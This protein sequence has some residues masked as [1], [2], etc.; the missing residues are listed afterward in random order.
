MIT[1]IISNTAKKKNLTLPSYITFQ[2]RRRAKTK[3][4]YFFLFSQQVQNL[5][6]KHVFLSKMI[7]WEHPRNVHMSQNKR[8]Y[9]VLQSSCYFSLSKIFYYVFLQLHLEKKLLSYQSLKFSIKGFWFRFMVFNATFNNI[10]VILWLSV[11]VLLV[12]ET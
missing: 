10:S 7:C 11:L 3:T 8:C 4:I 1:N 2:F 5:V 6:I 12:E 9:S